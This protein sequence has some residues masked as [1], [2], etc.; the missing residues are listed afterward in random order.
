WGNVVGQCADGV[1]Y[2][3]APIERERVA[4]C[5]QRIP[6]LTHRRL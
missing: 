4:R 6:C 1:G 5:R 2:V 3:L